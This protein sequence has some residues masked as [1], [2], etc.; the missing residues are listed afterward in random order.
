MLRV[1]AVIAVVAMRS[2]CFHAVRPD[3][4]QQERQPVLLFLGQAVVEGRGGVGQRLQRFALGE[5][6]FAQ[7]AQ[8]GDGV[9]GMG[10]RMRGFGAI[11]RALGARAQRGFNRRP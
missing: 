4:M 11:L 6:L 7:F 9:G 5:V 3:A 2:H 10:R 8:P 1:V